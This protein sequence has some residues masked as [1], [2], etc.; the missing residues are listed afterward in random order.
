MRSARTH[1]DTLM[2]HT[3]TLMT[4][5]DTLMTYMARAMADRASGAPLSGQ[6]PRPG[7][8]RVCGRR[9]KALGF[10]GLT[11]NWKPEGLHPTP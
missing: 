6:L 10:R 4:H 1:T 8:R 7:S 9:G 5:T 3:G 2:T 11:P